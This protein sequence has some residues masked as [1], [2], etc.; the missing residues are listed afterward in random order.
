M[1]CKACKKEDAMRHSEICG[2]CDIQ[3]AKDDGTF[4][5]L[6][7]DRPAAVP[8]HFNI[9]LGEH[10]EDRHD[11]KKKREAKKRAGEISAWD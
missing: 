4:R 3:G 9:S 6:M 2:L 10:V 8:S 1:K 11:L 5:G 7:T